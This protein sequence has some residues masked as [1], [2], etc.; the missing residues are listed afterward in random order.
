M[1]IFAAMEEKVLSLEK[2]SAVTTGGRRDLT[3]FWLTKNAFF[4]TS[5]N[6]KKTDNDAKTKNNIQSY[7][8][9]K[10]YLQ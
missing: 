7:Q 9:D 2:F 4:R 3:P 8:L 5:C 1:Q 6:D 10:S